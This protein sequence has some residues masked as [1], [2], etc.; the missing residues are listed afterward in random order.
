MSGQRQ[1]I[2]NCFFWLEIGSGFKD[3][4][5]TSP[6]NKEEVSPRPGTKVCLIRCPSSYRYPLCLKQDA[7]KRTAR[8]PMWL[9]S[10]MQR[11][12][13]VFT[14]IRASSFSFLKHVKT[15]ILSGPIDN[16]ITKKPLIILLFE[17]KRD[18][19]K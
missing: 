10:S 11:T 17:I 13:K 12:F 9:P 1:G 2:E 18:E 19:M 3:L 6:P 15:E 4:G 7:R 16:Q 14:T 8:D 5:G